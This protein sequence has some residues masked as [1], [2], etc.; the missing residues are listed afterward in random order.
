MGLKNN[1]ANRRHRSQNKPPFFS[2][3]ACA[4]EVVERGIL[5]P[6]NR[7]FESQ[8]FTT[9]RVKSPPAAWLSE[10]GTHPL[11]IKRVKNDVVPPRQ[12]AQ[13]VFLADHSGLASRRQSM[14]LLLEPVITLAESAQ[15]YTPL[16]N[17]CE[18]SN[19]MGV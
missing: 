3:V 5:F 9:D 14:Q 8:R 10:V 15:F 18:P 13:R 2:E 16:G 11:T 7:C 19:D 17:R 12:H 6:K 4:F 1:Q